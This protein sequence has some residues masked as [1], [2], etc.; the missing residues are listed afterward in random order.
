MDGAIILNEFVKEYEESI[1]L[2]NEIPLVFIDRDLHAP[3]VSSVI[4]DSFHGGEL[5]AKYLL[6]LGNSSFAYMAG[7]PNNFDNLKEKEDLR[8]LLKKQG[9]H[10]RKNMYWK[11][12]LRGNLLFM[13]L[14]I[15][16]KV[17]RNYLRRFLP[18]MMK[19]R[20]VRF[21]LC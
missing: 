11:V 1:I 5:A 12:Y 14:R 6:E 15:F 18:E 16:W 21:R 10:Y 20:L 17:E 7:V 13:R 2:E 4:F 9:I 8:Q 3:H 19:V